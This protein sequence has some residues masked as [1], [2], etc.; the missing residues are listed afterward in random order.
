MRFLAV[1]LALQLF[2]ALTFSQTLPSAATQNDDPST[3]IRDQSALSAAEAAIASMGGAGAAG[4]IHDCAVIG[5]L[6][7]ATGASWGTFNWKTA[8]REFRLEA[9]S[10]LSTRIL[11]SG[12]GNTYDQEEGKQAHFAFHQF[13]AV[14]TYHLPALVL[15]DELNNAKISF[16]YI[17]TE[18]VL[19]QS[20]LHFQ[21]SDDS[22]A[23]GKLVT[24]QDWYVDATTGIP[25]QLKF[26]YPG[27][28]AEEVV[29]VLVM[30]S[31]YQLASAVLMPYVMK[32]QIGKIQPVTHTVDSLVC[33]EGISPGEFDGP[34]G[35]GQ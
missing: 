23:V 18:N 4:G 30:Y 11:F 13:R 14:V 35:G 34:T 3:V 22:D 7:L 21:T 15:L 8:G 19:G 24:K 25:I 10:P 31:H 32:V 16:R 12:H 20:A 33:N 9:H 28:A 5:H 27:V 2:V 17:G 29:P 6:T 1:V 26:V